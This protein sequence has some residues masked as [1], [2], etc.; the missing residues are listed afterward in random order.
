MTLVSVV[1]PV[2]FSSA[3]LP[4]LLT[5]LRAVADRLPGVQFE[6]VMVDDGSGDHSYA[7]LKSEAAADPQVRALRLSRNFGSNAAILAGLAHAQGD[8]CVVIAADLQDPPELIPELVRAWQD[9]ADVVLAARRTRDD[10]FVS[11]T[12]ALI[13]NRL[14]R[15]LVFPDF[16]PNGFD[17]MAVSRRVARQ[18]VV[19]NERNSYI[20]GQIMW[21]GYERKVV[22]YDRAARE[23]GESRW[24]IAKKIK[25]FI[26]A[27]TAF[28]Y[29]PVRA[30]TLLGTLLAFLGFV[31]AGVVL[32]ARLLGWI[33]EAGFAAVMVALLVLSGTQLIVSGL[34]GEYLWRVLEESRNRPPYLVAQTV[35]LDRQDDGIGLPPAPGADGSERPGREAVP[36]SGTG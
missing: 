31:W 18:I 9:G 34:I 14:F 1:V 13:F 23:E 10:P 3:T 33:P 26:D 28:S 17:F 35:N 22:Y 19:M 6:Y 4:A 8:C 29:L 5:R 21:V 25:Y 27:F 7:V 32:V 36:T 20:F 30:A 24:T 15:R 11:R 12:F 16:P 2:Y